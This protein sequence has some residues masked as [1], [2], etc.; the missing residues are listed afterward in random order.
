MYNDGSA[1]LECKTGPQLN[2]A[3]ESSQ[4]KAGTVPAGAV[5]RDLAAAKLDANYT[6]ARSVSFGASET[7]LYD[8][9]KVTGFD[10][11][12]SQHPNAPLSRDIVQLLHMGKVH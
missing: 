6:C 10:C 12:L 3:C 4:F 8:G 11:Y 1:S 5:A 7:L 2:K 9:K